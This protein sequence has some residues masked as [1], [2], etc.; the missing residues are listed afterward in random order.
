MTWE[1]IDRL[2][3]K[4]HG[5]P[6]KN[7]GS[8]LDRK[9]DSLKNHLRLVFHRFLDQGDTRARNVTIAVDGEPLVPWDPFLHRWGVGEMVK[10]AT[11]ELRNSGGEIEKIGRASCRERV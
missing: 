1:K 9:R 3:L 7:P 11:I 10:E 2:L 4:Q 6:Y 8:A 5:E